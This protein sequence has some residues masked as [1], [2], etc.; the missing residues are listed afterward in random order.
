MIEQTFYFENR[1]ILN[2]YHKGF[3]DYPLKRELEEQKGAL[4][5]IEKRVNAQELKFSFKE[6]VHSFLPSNHE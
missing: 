3:P 1:K 4:R 6:S 5:L 2:I